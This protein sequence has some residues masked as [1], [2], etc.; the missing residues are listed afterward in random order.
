MK[1]VICLLAVMAFVV[2]S[3]RE[4]A[5]F[6]QYVKMENVIWE[7]FNIL[8]FEVPVKNG[9]RLDFFLFLRHHTDFP[10]DKLYVNITFYSPDGEMRSRDYTFDLKD[11]A[12]EWLSD[13]MGE[14]WDIEIPIRTGMPF[15]TAGNCRVRVENKYPKY[16]TPG[17]IE[18]GLIAKSSKE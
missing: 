9:D 6:R 10:Y 11:E 3:C 2:T 7:R 14:L 15:Y 4:S 12:G 1:K 18:V 5:V 17:I 13:G 16:N 8:E